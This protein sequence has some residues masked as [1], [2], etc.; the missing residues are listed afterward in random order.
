MQRT[1]CVAGY[2]AAWP[3]FPPASLQLVSKRACLPHTPPCSYVHAAEA[4]S[5]ASV[6]EG[7]KGEGT[8]GLDK[9]GS[10]AV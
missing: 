5:H 8:D 4:G 2:P 7:E 1:P 10:E 6:E 3:S 9:T